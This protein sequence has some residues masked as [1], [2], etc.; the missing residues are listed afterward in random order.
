MQI[1]LNGKKIDVPD[2][3]TVEDMLVSV[4]A[5]RSAVITAVNNEIVTEESRLA[6]GDKVKLISV[7]SGG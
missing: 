7:V 5:R 1:I 6:E 4:D 2:G 3:S